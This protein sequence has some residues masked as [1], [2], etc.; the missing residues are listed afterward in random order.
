MKREE[1]DQLIK[2]ADAFIGMCKAVV[3]QSQ[4]GLP[5]TIKE[6]KFDGIEMRDERGEFLP[7]ARL[8]SIDPQALVFFEDLKSTLDYLKRQ[9]D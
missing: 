5:S 8:I 9:A 7:M 3:T 2:E 4:L 1:A 6:C